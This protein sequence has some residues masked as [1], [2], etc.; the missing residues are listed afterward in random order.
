MQFG[1]PMDKNKTQGLVDGT[2]WN[3]FIELNR[4][5]FSDVLPRNSESRAL[6]VVLRIIKKRYPHIDW[7]LSFSD[8]AQCGD[9]TIYRASGFL[10]VGIRANKTIIKL[11]DGRLVA[12]IVINTTKHKTGKSI[13]WHLNNGAERLPGFKLK[14]I[15]FLNK[16][17]KNRL[18]VPIIPFS[19]IVKIGAG[20]YKG[21]SR[22]K[23][24]MFGSTE[25]AEGKHLP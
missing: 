10:L 25:T 1:P 6:G 15:Y 11:A 19:E 4:M 5:A 16:E 12:D 22:Y 20:M 17:A 24:A 2:G 18:T 23:H 14:Y 7:V 13:S 21:V 8:A 9:G 3:G